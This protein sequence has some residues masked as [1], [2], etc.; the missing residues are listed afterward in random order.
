MGRSI[1]KQLLRQTASLRKE[2]DE[3]I[4]EAAKRSLREADVSTSDLLGGIRIGYARVSTDDQALSMQLDSL[5]AAGCVQIYQE[6][7]SGKQTDRPE[8]AH[9]LKALRKG[10]TLV[11]WRLDRLGR[12]MPHLV[13]TI[14]G[15]ER[16]GASFESLTEKIETS[17][18]TGRLVFHLFASLAEFERNLISER[19][20]E[21]LKAARRR[22]VKGGRKPVLDAKAVKQVLALMADRSTRPADI[23]AQY[24][25]SKSTLYKI[26]RT[27][28]SV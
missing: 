7:A 26:V 23:A 16:L 5:K 6:T 20:K 14:G 1:A 12:S 28:A 3:S 22:G 25:I 27:G 8:L 24:K 4:S 13:E 9:A 18:A 19:T 10:D 2:L 17:S 21:G 11:V 15:I